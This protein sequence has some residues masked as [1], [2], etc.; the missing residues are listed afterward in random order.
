MYILFRFTYIYIYTAASIERCRAGDSKCLIAASS[1]VIRENKSGN[2]QLNLSP[3]DP[4]KIDRIDI[5]QGNDSPV[6]INLH[7]RNVNLTGLGELVV[8]KME[9]VILN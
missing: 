8:Y 5:E 6:N 7:F 3:I 9:Y 4:L 1:R 2:P